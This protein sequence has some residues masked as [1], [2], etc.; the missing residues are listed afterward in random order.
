[1]RPG[2]T[3][4]SLPIPRPATLGAGSGGPEGNPILMIRRLAPW[5]GPAC[6]LG[7][8]LFCYRGVL[9]FGGQFGYRDAAHYYYPLYQRV[10]SEW[11]AGRVPLWDPSENAGMPLLGNPTAAVLYPGKLIFALFA[12]PW[13]VRLYAVAHS[14]LACAG[15]WVLLRGWRASRTGATLA[16]LSYAFGAPVLFQY[17]NIIF[18]VGAAW[19]PWGFWAVDRW[20]RRERPGALLALAVV[21]AMQVLGG[22]PE[23]AYLVGLC[24]GG[25][26]WLLARDRTRQPVPPPSRARRL[27]RALAWGTLIVGGL[28]TWVAVTL[29]LAVWLPG[30]RPIPGEAP[31]GPVGRW[32][33][34]GRLP[35]F[36]LD[37][38]EGPVPGFAW[39][40]PLPK[41]VAVVWGAVGLLWLARWRRLGS[42]QVPLVP[43]L[44]GLVGAAALAG[45]LAAAQLLPVAEYTGISARATDEG[46]HDIYPFSLEPYRLV[47]LVWPGFFGRSFGSSVA[48][49]GIILP[50]VNH[51]TWVPSLYLGGLTL[52]FG[53]GVWGGRRQGTGE[54]RSPWVPWLVAIVGIGFVASFGEFASPIWLARFAPSLVRG[55][56]PHDSA[57]ANAVRLDG[58]LRDGDGSPYGLMASLLPGFHSFRFPSKLFTFVGLAL[59]CLAGLGW[60]RIARGEGRWPRRLAWVGLAASLL[61]GGGAV[62]GRASLVAWFEAAKVVTL[63]GPLDARGAAGDV[64]VAIGQG[65]VLCAAALGLIVWATRR[66]DHAGLAAI[67]VMAVDLGWANAAIVRAVPQSDFEVTPRVLARIA[68]AEQRDPSPGPYRVH[69]V[70]IWHPVRWSDTTSPDRIRDFERWEL[71]TIQPKYGLLHD[72]EYTQTLGVAELYDYEWFF[73]PFP[74]STIPEAARLLGINPGDKVVVYPRRGFDLWNSRYFVVPYMPRWDDADRGIAAF[75]PETTQVDP[76]PDAFT[77]PGGTAA[78]ERWAKEEDTK[79]LRNKN[80]YPR[81]WVVHDVRF[82]APVVGLGRKERKETM[83]EILFADDLFWRD[84]RRTVYDPKRLAWIETDDPAALVPY[85]TK[86]D[87]TRVETVAVVEHTS[88]RVVLE[89]DLERPGL[90]ILADVYYPGWSLTIDGQPAPIHRANRLMRAAAVPSGKKH[91]LVYTYNPASFRVGVALSGAGLVVLIGASTW[92]ARS[93]RPGRTAV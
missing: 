84:P 62:L 70:P 54:E 82:K 41:V 57:N 23:S 29:A 25:Y 3:G 78:R 38:Y 33:A 4:I 75:L 20:L 11:Q 30:F 7:L 22:D 86:G 72:V 69:R 63:F 13:A 19:I 8:L 85:I 18:L 28:A 1:M 53:L 92:L 90:V 89:A 77:G 35:H 27:T 51:R 5:F 65:G 17:C 42:K 74:R 45:A 43:M 56:G 14:A 49:M 55:I 31:W 6:M 73:A 44:A 26:A 58:F 80:A 24:S 68:E 39:V 34:T 67:V 2:P 64:A 93:A 66:P 71:A 79:I 91:R 52:I 59:A 16:G 12:Y 47:E 61:A 76:P 46:P 50:E 36:R 10:Q 48:W 15:V 87:P 40:A 9:F 21:L 81:A 32:L 83:E 37:L 88:N 60:D